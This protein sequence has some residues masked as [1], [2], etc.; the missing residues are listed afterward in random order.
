VDV[1]IL[2][3]KALPLKGEVMFLICNVFTV[4]TVHKQKETA[5]V[6]Q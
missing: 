3:A 4:S 1:L 6:L 5:K 2:Q